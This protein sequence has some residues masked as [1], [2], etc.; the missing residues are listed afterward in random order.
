MKRTSRALSI[1]ACAAIIPLTFGAAA[2]P[3]AAADPSPKQRLDDLCVDRGGTVYF[4]PYAV[5]RCQEARGGRLRTERSVCEQLIGGTFTAVRSASRPG[6]V[7][8][9]CTPG[10]PS[11]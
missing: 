1:A 3:A 6:R 9:A 10:A 7:N 2:D 4:S 11:D 8:W 5:T